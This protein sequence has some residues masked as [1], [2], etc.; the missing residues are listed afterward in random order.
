MPAAGLP[1]D[2]RLSIG[3]QTIHRRTEPATGP[4][5]PRIDDLVEFVARVDRCGY[6]SLWVG[7][8]VAFTIP[9]LDPLQTLAQAAVASRRLKLGTGVYLLPLRHPGPAAKEV[10][11]LDHLC[12]GRLI[13]GVGVGGE[14]PKEFEVCGVKRAERGARLSESIAVL[15]KL[16][17]GE[18]V[19][20]QGR[21]F[22]FEDVR[23]QPPP[24]QVGGP[25]IW[26][27]G[28]SEAALAR[29]GRLADGWLSYVV[30]PET[31]AAS[32]AKI[33]AAADKV[34]RKPG[35]F[36]TGH[37]LFA[38]LDDSYE[39]ALD[40]AAETLSVRYAM[41]FRAAARRYAALG[42]AG[43]IAERIR[44][45][46]AGGVRHLSIDLLGPFEERA[47]QIERFAAEVLPLIDDLREGR[48]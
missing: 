3:I 6:D 29:A 38:R 4:W 35:H 45:F 34:G 11:S 14:F 37:L 7:D 41:D 42:T 19:S 20:H 27:G 2:D 30:T 16:W 40:I 48:S 8:H 39:K 5:L 21:F 26:C 23:M 44:A 25:P 12:E 28:R 36:G 18:P 17:S 32:L 1:L 9:I 22:A 43:Q 24:R 15:R 46:H 13:F 33:A 47:V 31:Y 10:A